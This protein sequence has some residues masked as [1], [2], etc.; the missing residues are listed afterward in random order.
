[1]SRL[2]T[3][4]RFPEAIDKGLASARR[5]MEDQDG[6]RAI[7]AA[8]AALVLDPYPPEVFHQSDYHRLRAG[9]FRVI[10]VVEDDLITVDRVERVGWYGGT[11]A[12]PMK[13]FQ[14][15]PL[16]PFIRDFPASYVVS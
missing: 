3:N 10:Y 1:M 2:T 7:V 6:M 5:Y 12:A 15:L 11:S 14:Y 8:V 4:V 13:A 16:P 9:R